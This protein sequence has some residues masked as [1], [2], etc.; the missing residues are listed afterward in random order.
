MTARRTQLVCTTVS[1]ASPRVDQETGFVHS[2]FC[3]SM[4]QLPPA[5]VH[6]KGL[7]LIV[8]GLG[9]LRGMWPAGVV[10]ALDGEIIETDRVCVWS[11]GN[12]AHTLITGAHT[13]MSSR[14]E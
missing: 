11:A 5:S 2:R 4:C 10:V 3:V 6:L 1:A 12:N 7:A 14:R 8:I 13:M 9:R